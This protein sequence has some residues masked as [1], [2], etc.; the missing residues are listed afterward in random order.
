MCW[1]ELDRFLFVD[2]FRNL[3]F[4][5]ILLLGI[6]AET[7]A[8]VVSLRRANLGLERLKD[9]EVRRAA[10]EERARL[11]RELHDGLAQDLWLAKLK[12]SRLAAIPDLGP[13]ASIV[14]DELGAAIDAGVAEARQ[15][16]MALRVAQ[17]PGASFAGLLG[18]CVDDFADRFGVRAE[19]ACGDVPRLTTRVEAELLRITQEALSNVRRHADATVVWV[20]VEVAGDRVVLTVRDNGRGFDPTAVGET[21][22]GLTSM[23]ER[24]SLIGAQLAI[25][26]RPRDGSCVTVALPLPAT[27]PIPPNQATA[28]AGRPG[29]GASR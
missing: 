22:F 3:A 8:Y 1:V 12:V 29:T 20:R 27:A 2:E 17:Q 16:V 24:A 21:G 28:F 5:V 25:E 9:A 18:R 7:G 10:I 26:S 23:R 14:C 11:S 15:A 6:Q 19:F 13:E 4:D